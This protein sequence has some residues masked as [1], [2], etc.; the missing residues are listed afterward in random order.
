MGMSSSQDLRHLSE[1]DSSSDEHGG[2]LSYAYKRTEEPPRNHE[3]KI[4]C[5]HQ[6]CTGVVFDRKCEWR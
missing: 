4:I 3:A 2:S 1:D 6:E 5:K